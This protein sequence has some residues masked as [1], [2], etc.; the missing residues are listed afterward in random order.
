[1]DWGYGTGY[2]ILQMAP[3]EG[4]QGPMNHLFDLLPVS[5]RKRTY[6]FIKRTRKSNH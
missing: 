1:M 4:T 5:S 3:L 6:W 2:Q